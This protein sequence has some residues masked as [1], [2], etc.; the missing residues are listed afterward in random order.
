MAEEQRIW[1]SID[2]WN[3]DTITPGS[4]L[5]VK[6][7]VSESYSGMNV[8]IPIHIRRAPEDG[9]VIFVT[10]ALHGDEINGTGAVRQLIQDPDLNLLR[11]TVIFVPVLNLLGFDHHSRYLPDRRDLNRSFP[12]SS[13][14][15]LA[16]R[17]ARKIFDEIIARCDYGIDLHTAA[18]RRTNYPNIRADLGRPETKEL[19]E[20]FGC[21]IIFAGKGPR[22]AL[23]RSACEAGCPTIIM[24]GGEVWKVQ[25]SIVESAV[26]GVQNVL[27]HF[28]MIEGEPEMPHYQVTITQ[29]KWIRAERG[30]FL[31][32]HIQPGEIVEEG[33]PLATNTT[34][35]GH[36]RS[37]LYAPYDGVVIGM[38]TLPSVSPGEPVCHVGKL[39]EGTEPS[40][41]RRMRKKEDGLETRIS[42]EM[43]THVMVT[44]PSEESSNGT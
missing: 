41:L 13:T 3:G 34:L 35:L 40:K 9:P 2:T 37:T 36:E 4:A 28:K 8:K 16:S 6:L 32:F 14:G 25:P 10:A 17:M 39:P 31:Q 1:K 29:A 24:E 22:G 15:S 11:G 5:D 12:G 43:S 23:R 19:A 21:E 18:V 7:A 44:E 20:A 38:T 42:E 30:G 27:R 26:R 33:Q